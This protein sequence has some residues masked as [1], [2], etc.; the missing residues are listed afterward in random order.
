MIGDPHVGVLLW[1]LYCMNVSFPKKDIWANTMW[2]YC[3]NAGK[4]KQQ[5][6]I[7]RRNTNICIYL[8]IHNKNTQNKRYK[9]ERGNG[10]EEKWKWKTI[11]DGVWWTM[12]EKWCWVQLKKNR[13]TQQQVILL[14]T[15]CI[16]TL[17]FIII[18]VHNFP[19]PFSLLFFHTVCSS[20]F[21]I[22]LNIVAIGSLANVLKQKRCLNAEY[23]WEKGK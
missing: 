18:I 20:C 16:S 2:K 8:V 3:E 17:L 5:G 1:G 23:D 19:F 7:E 21:V 15:S 14:F 10:K 22:F 11:A 9:R 12:G 6:D 13:R 4:T